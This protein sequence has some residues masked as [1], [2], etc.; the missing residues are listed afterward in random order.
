MTQTGS[1]RPGPMFWS[2]PVWGGGLDEA[3]ECERA[4]GRF[5]VA[6]V[7]F[8]AGSGALAGVFTVGVDRG[9]V[10]DGAEDERVE[11]RLARR[12]ADGCGEADP[13]LGLPR[14]EVFE[15]LGDGVALGVHAV[16]VAEEEEVRRIGGLL[17]ADVQ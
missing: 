5:L 7:V 16:E 10:V 9:G 17:Q 15:H 2:E 14:L 4:G 11:V 12:L 6:D 8:G 1:D 13:E 3:F